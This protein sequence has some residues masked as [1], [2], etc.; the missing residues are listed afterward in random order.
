MIFLTINDFKLKLSTDILAQITG[1]DASINDDAENHAIGLINDAFS[2][3]FD[4]A[5]ELAKTGSD[6]HANLL[7][8]L[9]NLTVYFIYERI[10]DKQVP[11]RV[12]KNYNDT[13][14][15]IVLIE[16]GKRSTTLTPVVNETTGLK[17]TVFRWGS[18]EK[19]S[20]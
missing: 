17:K 9:L 4:I 11:E 3:K 5:T 14:D 6:R 16:R 20:H 15:E 19:R 18:T 10:P 13:I 8:W 7:R 12:V 1:N 2:A